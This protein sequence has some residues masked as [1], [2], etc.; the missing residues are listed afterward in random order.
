MDYF[1]ELIREANVVLV[2]GACGEAGECGRFGR[3]ED[4]L[5]EEGGRGW[6]MAEVKAKILVYWEG[7]KRSR[8]IRSGAVSGMGS[9]V[10]DMVGLVMEERIKRRTEGRGW[11][12]R[13]GV[14]KG[15]PVCG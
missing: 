14:V 9:V 2:G 3:G 13:W 10:V 12:R 1:G 4:G 6:I 15:E 5:R 7:V 8:W 11:K